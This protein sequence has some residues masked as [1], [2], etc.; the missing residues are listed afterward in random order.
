MTMRKECFFVWEER[1]LIINEYFS[2]N[3]TLYSLHLQLREKN[4]RQR[5]KQCLIV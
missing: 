5:W 3:S 4:S 2:F 1:H